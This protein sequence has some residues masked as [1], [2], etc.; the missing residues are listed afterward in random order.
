MSSGYLALLIKGCISNRVAN[1]RN[2]LNEMLT[3]KVL[4]YMLNQ[5]G[6]ALSETLKRMCETRSHFDQ[7]LIWTHHLAGGTLLT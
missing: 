6:L 3:F 7:K 5:T 1:A 2:K 4:F